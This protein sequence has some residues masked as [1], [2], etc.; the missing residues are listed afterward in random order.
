MPGSRRVGEHFFRNPL[1][2]FLREFARRVSLLRFQVP[3]QAGPRLIFILEL[4][5]FFYGFDKRGGFGG[6][7]G[8]E[9]VEFWVVGVVALGPL[10]A[11]PCPR[12]IPAFFDFFCPDD[13]RLDIGHCLEDFLQLFLFFGMHRGR[14]DEAHLVVVDLTEILL[15]QELVE[16]DECPRLDIGLRSDRF[17]K[18]PEGG[19]ARP[20]FRSRAEL[21]F[22][23]VAISSHRRDAG[24]V[25]MHGAHGFCGFDFR[26]RFAR[27]EIGSHRLDF[28]DELFRAR[29]IVDFEGREKL[30]RLLRKIQR[31]ALVVPGGENPNG[32]PQKE[33]RKISM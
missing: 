1:D 3:R 26:Q 14:R 24:L 17:S 32:S 16:I 31:P 29:E 4:L 5:G 10:G 30:V 33:E 27:V 2:P 12:G 20:D 28:V 23:R 15:A 13:G 22:E 8:A 7:V 6:K 11:F 21:V 18:F 25:E 9:L 19:V